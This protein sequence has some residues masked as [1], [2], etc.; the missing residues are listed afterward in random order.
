M[1]M[2]SQGNPRFLVTNPLYVGWNPTL[3][4]NYKCSYCGQN[5]PKGSDWCTLENTLS[6]FDRILELGRDKYIFYLSGGEP[7]INPHLPAAIKYISQLFEDKIDCVGMFSNGSAD[8]SIYDSLADIKSSHPFNLNISIHTEH[9]KDQKIIDIVSNLS[10]RLTLRLDLMFN[11]GLRDRV[12][13]IHALLLKLRESYPFI[14]YIVPLLDRRRAN[15]DPRYTSED[16]AWK[17]ESTSRFN[18]IAVNSPKAPSHYFEHLYPLMNRIFTNEYSYY[19]LNP[20][21]AISDGTLSLRGKYC[22]LGTHILNIN[23]SGRCEGAICGVASANLTSKP[24]FE[25]NPYDDP[26]FC[27]VVEC[28]ADTCS[29]T[30]NSMLQKFTSKKEA[31]DFRRFHLE[32]QRLAERRAQNEEGLKKTIELQ[33][34]IIHTLGSDMDRIHEINAHHKLFL[35]HLHDED[36]PYEKYVD[37]NF[38]FSQY[39]DVAQSGMTAASHFSK[40]GWK[41]DRDPAPWF[42]TKYYLGQMQSHKLPRT[43]PLAHFV[44]Y[45]TLQGWKCKP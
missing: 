10:N 27:K 20:S 15:L 18:E 45:G 43:N 9:I 3:H 30:V 4:C 28:T 24:I 1:T 44:K 40:Y 31:D 6:T 37:Q 22:V 32:R 35:D 8:L 25:I 11:P 14:S 7:T 12:R 2:I 39:P 36:F 38:Y 33:N 13:E 26:N 42:D 41:E 21:Q 5:R 17:D 19:E 34:Q 23:P 29:C 16:F